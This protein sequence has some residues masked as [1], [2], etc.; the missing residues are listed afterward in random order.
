MHRTPGQ[1]HVPL[2]QLAPLYQNLPL[3]SQQC[4]TPPHYSHTPFAL[5]LTGRSNFQRFAS[6]PTLNLRT[7]L[8]Y[9]PGSW[10]WVLVSF[11]GMQRSGQRWTEGL[12][13]LRGDLEICGWCSVVQCGVVGVE[14]GRGSFSLLRNTMGPW[15]L[16]EMPP[17]LPHPTAI[18]IRRELLNPF[19]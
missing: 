1:I 11:S 16:K 2:T 9:S 12:S 3:L 15:I 6:P 13:Q 19:K 4:Y 8:L 14:F 17:P 5:S 18:I 10:L 7:L